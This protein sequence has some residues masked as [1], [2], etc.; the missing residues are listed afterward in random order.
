[1]SPQ[2]LSRVATLLTMLGAPAAYANGPGF[3]VACKECSEVLIGCLETCS[4]RGCDTC[5]TS[6]ETCLV[7]EGC[8]NLKPNC[9]QC[10]E[11]AETCADQC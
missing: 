7:K 8:E 5:V 9:D 6:Y 10:L 1:M 11:D 2:T 3:E 4:G